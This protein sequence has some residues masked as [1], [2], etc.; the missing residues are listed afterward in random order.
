MLSSIITKKNIGGLKLV[1]LISVIFIFKALLQTMYIKKTPDRQK[2][3]E[4]GQIKINCLCLANRIGT[5][6]AF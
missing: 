2:Y 6:L 1:I 4:C 3:R 5:V